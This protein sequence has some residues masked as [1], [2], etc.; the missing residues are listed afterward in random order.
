[1]G[2]C[3]T[4]VSDAVF[5]V[6]CYPCRLLSTTSNFRKSC[7]GLCCLSIDDPK[8]CMWVF[9]CCFNKKYKELEEMDL[10]EGQFYKGHTL[11][12]EDGPPESDYLFPCETKICG[13]S[14]CKRKTC[15]YCLLSC[16][17]QSS[18]GFARAGARGARVLR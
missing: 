15:G 2:G 14:V 6:V 13:R 8:R 5:R 1:M 9:P 3:A 18:R 16:C 10:I 11:V 17:N 7:R 4:K 12:L